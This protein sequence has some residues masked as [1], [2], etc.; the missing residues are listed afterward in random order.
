MKPGDHPEFFRLPP[1]PGTSRQSAI[2]LDR[3]GRFFHEG[4]LV[5]KKALAAAMHAW[6]TTHPDDGRFILS[7]GYDWCYL[8]VEDTPAFVCSL[9]GSPPGPPLLVLAD[10]TREPLDASTLTQDEEGTC[11]ARVKGGRFEARFLLHAQREL[12]PWL[13][14]DAGAAAI[15][16][17][18]G[19]RPIPLRS[20]RPP[21]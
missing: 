15:D 9:S 8:T 7:N 1:P 16:V 10:G 14:D 17:G 13:V 3:Q 11:F 4:A 21:Q 18:Q 19:P 2:V 20:P 5:E 6:L 12:E